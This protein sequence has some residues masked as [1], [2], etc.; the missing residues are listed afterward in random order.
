MSCRAELHIGIPHRVPQRLGDRADVVRAGLLRMEQDD[1]D[2]AAGGQQSSGVSPR[3][4]NGPSVR[5]TRTEGAEPAVHL[6]R[7]APS[8][9][10]SGKVAAADEVGA[11]TFHERAVESSSHP[12]YSPASSN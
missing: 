2:V 5:K 3:G 8:Q 12:P 1:V 7:Q 9:A 10:T 4:D 6:I 11:R